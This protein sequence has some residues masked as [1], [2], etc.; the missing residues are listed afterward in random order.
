MKVSVLRTTLI[1]LFEITRTVAIEGPPGIGKT[2]LVQQVADELGVECVA[3]HAPTMLVEDLGILDMMAKPVDDAPKT[4]GYIM[5][6]WFPAAG[7]PHDTGKGGILLIDDR[8]QCGPDIQKV[9]ANLCEARTLHGVKMANKWMVIATGNRQADRA[10]S[11]RVLSH[12]RDRE[13]VLNLEPNL[14]DWCTY[15]LQNGVRSEVVAFVRYRPNALHDFDPARDINSSPRSLVKGVSEVLGLVPE[16][17]ELECIAG[18][19]GE[20]NAAEFLGFMRIYRDL[21]T[22]A[23]IFAKPD[24]ARVPKD[25]ATLYAL[26]GALAYAVTKDTA[27]AYCTFITRMPPEFNVLSISMALKKNAELASIKAVTNHIASTHHILF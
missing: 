27:K 6:E 5:P 19:I 18:A 21:D 16:E 14:D 7:G 10:G 15:A 24:T 3:L 20:G 9:L 23:E 17:A 13:T 8:N 11:G 2:T 22:P 26:A 12:L 4:F 1:K 25:P